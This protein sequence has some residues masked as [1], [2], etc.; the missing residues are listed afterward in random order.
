MSEQEWIDTRQDSTAPVKRRMTKVR[1]D[2]DG[3]GWVN[4]ANGWVELGPDDECGPKLGCICGGCV[5]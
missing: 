4:T 3:T 1:I 5:L 2:P